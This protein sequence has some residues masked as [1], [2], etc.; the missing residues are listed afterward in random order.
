MQL[1]LINHIVEVLLILDL[2]DGQ[3]V[4][5]LGSVCEHQLTRQTLAVVEAFRLYRYRELVVRLGF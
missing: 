2:Y 5:V 3:L 1:L 4:G